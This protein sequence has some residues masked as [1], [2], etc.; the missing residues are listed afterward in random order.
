MRILIVGAGALGQPFGYHLHQ[1][2]ADIAYSVKPEY[3]DECESGFTL[4]RYRTFG[5][6]TRLEFEDYE[7]YVE[8]EEISKLDWDQVWL[9]VS[10]TAVR[11]DWLPELMGAVGETTLVSIQ[12]GLDVREH[13]ESHYPAERIVSGR[14]SMIAW[15]T[16]LG[17][18]SLPEGDI[19]YFLPP[20]Q[21]IY[22]GG[23]SGRAGRVAE[24]LDSGGCP[25][26]THDQV[27]S[28]GA[29]TS[30]ILET[31]V[32][33][34]E[35]ADWSLRAFRRSDI[36]ETAA[37]AGSEALQ[38]VAAKYDRRPPWMVRIASRSLTMRVGLPVFSLVMPFDLEAYLE[39][40]FTKVGDQTREEIVEFIET[41]E[42]HG[43]EVGSLRSLLRALP[44]SDGS[45]A[46]LDE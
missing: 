1:G 16:P 33:G 26:D 22:F 3:L 21:P 6:P 18:E 7:V 12:P 41:G 38:V 10:S 15:P 27:L 19:A 43:L 44:E 32:A 36:L 42:R 13:L 14:V 24:L 46:A 35:G 17:D 37:R 11:G 4:H 29:F 5:G 34:L 30:A 8:Y 39:E 20:A 2:G 23:G 40:H 45:R 9:C 25:A 28:Y 31:A